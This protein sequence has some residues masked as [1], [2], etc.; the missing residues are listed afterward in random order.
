[1]QALM[2]ITYTTAVRVFE[3]WRYE[4]QSTAFCRSTAA[5][6]LWQW[7]SGVQTVAFDYWRDWVCCLPSFLCF[8][9]LGGMAPA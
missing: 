6:L 8:S 9:N 5:R 3:A 4:A 2:H 1:M 7:Q